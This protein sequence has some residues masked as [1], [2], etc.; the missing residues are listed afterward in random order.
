MGKKWWKWLKNICVISL[1]SLAS[2]WTLSPHRDHLFSTIWYL[3]YIWNHQSPGAAG[4][5]HVYLRFP[6]TCLR[7]T[8]VQFH[9]ASMILTRDYLFHHV[10]YL[11]HLSWKSLCAQDTVGHTMRMRN[12]SSVVKKWVTLWKN[13]IYIFILWPRP[14]CMAKRPCGIV[15]ISHGR[16]GNPRLHSAVFSSTLRHMTSCLCPYMEN[17]ITNKTQR[18]MNVVGPLQLYISRICLDHLAQMAQTEHWK[19]II[20]L[21]HHPDGPVSAYFTRNRACSPPTWLM[22]AVARVHAVDVGSSSWAAISWVSH[23]ISAWITHV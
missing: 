22:R 16:F 6:H 13:K 5:L 8:G 23:W 2:L 11:E 19:D 17:W 14:F 4:L 10:T 21:G 3:K 20:Y 1:G 12:Y 9:L 18:T 7:V 15:W